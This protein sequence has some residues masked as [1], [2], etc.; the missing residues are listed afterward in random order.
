MQFNGLYYTTGSCCVVESLSMYTTINTREVC[1]LQIRF[2]AFLSLM[3]TS[4]CFWRSQNG[5]SS[6]EEL[7]SFTIANEAELSSG[8][9]YIGGCSITCGSSATTAVYTMQPS[10]LTVATCHMRTICISCV[11]AFSFSPQRL[12][13]SRPD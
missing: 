6:I 3:Q 9:T 12:L 8:W 10:L 11:Y 4:V 7:R 13:Q 5:I 2:A 1:K